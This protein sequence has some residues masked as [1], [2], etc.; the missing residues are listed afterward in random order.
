MCGIVGAIAQRPVAAILLEGLRRLEYRGYDS[1]GMA[2]LE[3]P[4]RLNRIRTLGKVAKLRD[5]VATHPLAGTLGIAHTRW[6]THGEPATR[7]AHPHVCRDRCAVVHNGI[8]E[9]HEVLRREQA[10]AG[11]RFTS[12]TDTE[13]V[14]HAIYDDARGRPSPDRGGAPRHR[15]HDRGLCPGG[16]RH[17]GPGAPGGRPPGEPAGDR[18]G[19][20][21][22]LHRLRRL[23]PAARHPPLHFPGRGGHRGAEPGA[24]AHLGPGRPSGRAADQGV[25]HRYRLGGAGHLPALHAE[26][27]LRAAP[28]HRRHPG[29]QALR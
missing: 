9:N 16:H 3:A 15:A 23:R 11:H 4:G 1:A 7:N 26:R 18:G 2:V 14:V 25:P 29:G 19:L 20:R 27:D 12:E 6:A 21:G 17:P 5:E 28:R 22:A 24:G 8:I 10:A 13:V